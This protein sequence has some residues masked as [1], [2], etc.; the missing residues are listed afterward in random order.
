MIIRTSTLIKW[1][2]GK[3][4]SEYDRL[5]V[6]ENNGENVDSEIRAFLEKWADA[7]GF[8]PMGKSWKNKY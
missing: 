6:R 8:E 1:L 2:W 5:L 7:V 3:E 4:L